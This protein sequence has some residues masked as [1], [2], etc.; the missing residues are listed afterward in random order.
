MI[1]DSERAFTNGVHRK[2]LTAI[3]SVALAAALGSMAVPAAALA[4]YSPDNANGKAVMTSAGDTWNSQLKKLGVKKNADGTKTASYSGI[5]HSDLVHYSA[6]G[7][8]TQI[9]YDSKG[10]VTAINLTSGN[11]TFAGAWGYKNAAKQMSAVDGY[12]PDGC[13]LQVTGDRSKGFKPVIAG[14]DALGYSFAGLAY[15]SVDDSGK[16]S[17]VTPKTT[18][19]ASSGSSKGSKARPGASAAS[20]YDD[21]NC[22]T[23]V[24]AVSDKSVNVVCVT[25][26]IGSES[27]L[28]FNTYFAI[29]G[30]G[31][32]DTNA[33]S[34][35]NKYL[36]T[37]QATTWDANPTLT[38]TMA[39]TNRDKWT[40]VMATVNL[41]RQLQSWSKSI[42]SGFEDEAEISDLDTIS[43]ATKTSEPFVEALNQAYKDG[44][45]KSIAENVKVTIDKGKSNAIDVSANPADRSSVAKDASGNYVLSN[46]FPYGEDR[47]ASHGTTLDSIETYS[48][49]GKTTTAEV[50]KIAK[51]R[52]DYK[53]LNSYT[54]KT[55]IGYEEDDGDP[56][57]SEGWPDFK[58]TTGDITVDYDS[59]DGTAP[60]KVTVNNKAITHLALTYTIGHG[61]I[62]VVY[63]LAQM[64]AAGK[65]TAQIKAMSASNAKQVA[66]ARK[67]YNA[68]STD[69][70]GFVTNIDKLLK[71]EA[72]KTQSI[73]VTPSSKTVKA[74][75]L[76]KSAKSFSIKV[77]GA[78]GKLSY[79]VASSSKK[80]LSVSKTGKVT[81]KKG[82][83]KGSYSVTVKAASTSKYAAATKTVTV[84]VK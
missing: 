9:T 29:A 47:S 7:L 80:A 35:A 22:K 11:E 1:D 49:S 15:Y 53:P 20:T 66:A 79:S 75:A 12:L 61:T 74:S 39:E 24:L 6:Y 23:G 52:S 83:K 33:S 63:D 68:L 58:D 62:T 13:S 25:F 2:R 50:A 5:A 48:I 73:K 65:V 8:E 28:K 67:A 69:V 42:K 40:V 57:Y 19:A 16:A 38:G 31:S 60:I 14:A 82:T 77:T 56:I 21:W 37:V 46:V 32:V 30:D 76:K 45:I 59:K 18:T 3:G 4:S 72:G 51:G 36:D 34:A 10:K 43:G 64:E 81:V 41:Q 55:V 27:A 78:K 54:P 26:S 70:R 84:K 17:A 44:Y 71:A